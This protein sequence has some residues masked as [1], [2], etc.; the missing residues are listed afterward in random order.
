MSA[1]CRDDKERFLS[2]F[3]GNKKED[4]SSGTAAGVWNARSA[5][6]TA[7]SAIPLL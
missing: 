2:S 4:F 7:R 5:N 1:P 3:I 6:G